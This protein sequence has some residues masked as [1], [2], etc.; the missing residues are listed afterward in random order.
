[1]DFTTSSHRRPA[2]TSKALAKANIF[3]VEAAKVTLPL[4]DMQLPM[5]Q[6]I[7]E[8]LRER[9]ESVL[10]MT[11]NTGRGL[12]TSII[13]EHIH[14]FPWLTR[15][16]VNHYIATH[17]DVQPIDT[18]IVTNINNRTVMS[19]LTDSSPIARATC[20]D[21]A[22]MELHLQLYQTPTPTGAS[23]TTTEATD[24]K[25]RRGGLPQGSTVGSINAQK[26]LLS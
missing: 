22:V 10:E 26:T 21:E 1:M 24:L 6:S 16:M 25:S 19:G 3:A 17:Q 2:R 12:L 4:R 23:T 13:R 14:Q 8:V 9:R 20:D 15:H 7:V 5:L 18:V 11:G